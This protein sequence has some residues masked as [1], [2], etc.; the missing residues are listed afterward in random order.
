M[1]KIVKTIRKLWHNRFYEIAWYPPREWV[2]DFGIEV[3]TVK[4]W[5]RVI[6][7]LPFASIGIGGW[8]FWGK[9]PQDTRS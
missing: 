7:W 8:L 2:C 1:H 5:L 9:R 6:V 3:P 4:N